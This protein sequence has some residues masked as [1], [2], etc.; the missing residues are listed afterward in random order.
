MMNGR[1]LKAISGFYSVQCGNGLIECRAKGIFRKRGLSPA[2]GDEVT[3]SVDQNEKGVI[4]E[5]SPRKNA[6]IRPPMAN[7]DQFIVV[8]SAV[9]PSP[10][11]FVVDKL[12]SIAEY[13]DVEPIIVLTKLDMAQLPGVADIY[14][15]AGFTVIEVDYQQKAWKQQV[16]DCLA[17]KVSAFCGN[18]GV[19]KSTLLNHLGLGLS[20]KTGETS[21]KL[22]RGRHT[23]RHVELF[24]L[25]FGG[26]I[27]DTPG[28]S[29]VDLHRQE[30]ILKDQLQYTFREI[31]PLVGQC[32]FV[33]CSHTCEKGCAVLAALEQ[34]KIVP[35][36]H[37]SYVALYQAVKDIKDWQL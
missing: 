11:L 17:G 26:Y 34:G 9:S 23:T 2:V 15:Q 29:D 22:G 7:I 18:S 12:L 33:G 28:F 6:F 8:V 32:K 13:K 10:N 31:A 37:Q 19:G 27:A 35:S 21:E 20:L 3:I 5:I 16:L 30:G 14:R 4:E 36:R 24:Q 1:I 25:P